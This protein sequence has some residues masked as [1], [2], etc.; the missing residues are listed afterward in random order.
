MTAPPLTG[1]PL[2]TV[3]TPTYNRAHLIK[4]V[5]QSLLMQTNKSFE[6]VIVDDGSSDDTE[7]VVMRWINR[8]PFKITYVKQHNQGK[9]AAYNHAVRL[10]CGEFLACLDSDDWLPVDGVE[11]R[12]KIMQLYIND[13]EIC[14]ISGLA[15]KAD[16]TLVGQSFPEDGIVGSKQLLNCLSPGDKPTTLKTSVIKQFPFPQF[17]NEKFLPESCVYNRLFQSGYKFASSNK[18]L[19]IVEY[20]QGGLSDTALELR[21][22]NI[23]GTLMYYY[24]MSLMDFS[25]GLKIRAKSNIIRYTIH[26]IGI[27][28]MMKYIIFFFIAV[29]TGIIMYLKDKRYNIFRVN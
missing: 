26:K 7:Q 15:E 18:I 6:W 8:A 2:L 5:Y 14:G 1:P 13:P 24:E 11:N 20:Q 12:I 17:P 9:P 19:T 10:A 4:R 25:S 28:K 16:G 27:L 21:L 3:I 22:N 23:N 29:P